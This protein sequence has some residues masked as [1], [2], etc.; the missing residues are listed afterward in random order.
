MQQRTERTIFINNIQT[1]IYSCQ[2]AQKNLKIGMISA[3]HMLGSMKELVIP[4]L[5][6]CP[7]L[8]VDKMFMCNNTY[9]VGG[10]CTDGSLY[11]V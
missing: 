3:C 6:F 4:K 7:C 9:I 10:N 8:P 1:Y 2:Y 11:F 5:I